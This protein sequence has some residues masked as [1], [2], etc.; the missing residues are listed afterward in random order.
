MPHLIVDSNLFRP[1]GKVGSQLGYHKYWE[2]V[3]NRK[4][5]CKARLMYHNGVMELK[6][7]VHN[8][9]PPTEYIQQREITGNTYYMPLKVP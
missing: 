4:T 9:Y 5:G 7:R 1:S 6:C 8:H 3:Q 2:C